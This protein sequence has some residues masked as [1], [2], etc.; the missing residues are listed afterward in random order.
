MPSPRDVLTPDSLA[1]LQAIADTGS[2]A[3]AAR[4][5]H[6]VPSAL[7][8]RVRQMEE[9][10]DVL[11]FDRSTRQAQAT[12]AGQALL[13]EG[14]RLLQ[15]IDAVAHRVRRVA[16]GWEPELT[17]VADGVIS[18]ATL[19]DLVEA[20]YALKSPTRIKLGMGTL[21]G[22]VEL[23]ST[24]RADLALGVGSNNT[25]VPGLQLED[26]GD[27]TFVFAVAPFHPLAQVEQPITDELLLEHR[28][29]V[30]ADSAQRERTSIGLLGGQDTFTVDTV[31]AK[32]DAQV[33][34][35]GC[36]FLP[37]SMAR[38]YVEAGL[39]VTKPVTRP[40]RQLRMRYAWKKPSSG[41]LGKA[42]HWWLTQLQ[43]PV[44]QK[45]LL[46]DHRLSPTA[47]AGPVQV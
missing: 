26:L 15:D 36:G 14:I 20:F 29:I 46:N 10:L 37:E 33:R 13:T 17:L 28:L 27:I 42:L 38:P 40:T 16:T 9:A 18:Q 45:A 34:G 8:Y 19:F 47:V 43:S 41:G 35:L 3:A 12:E 44:T 6:L 5:L 22:P 23:L 30:V 11:L 25:S 31:Q 2:F 1:M 24:G 7:T 39:L 32:I 21:T 4:Q